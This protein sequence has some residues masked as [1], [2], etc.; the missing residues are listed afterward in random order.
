[1]S[2]QLTIEAETEAPE[3]AQDSERQLVVFRLATETYGL[4]IGLVRE[5]IRPQAITHVPNMPGFVEGVINLRGKICPVIDLLKRLGVAVSEPTDESRIVIV[6]SS[7][8]EAG[9][10]VDAVIEVLSIADDRVEAASVAV[11]TRGASFVEGVANLESR[12][13]ILMNLETVLSKEDTDDWSQAEAA[14]A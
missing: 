4:D 12:L 3:Q 7:G 5:I 2:E 6:D 11:T 8:E 10:V 14:A 1:M 9:V 13:I